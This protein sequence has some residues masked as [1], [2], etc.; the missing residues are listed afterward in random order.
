MRLV[1]AMAVMLA[2]ILGSWWYMLHDFR[3]HATAMQRLQNQVSVLVNQLVAT[4]QAMRQVSALRQ[5]V[6]SARRENDARV[7]E[8]LGMCGIERFDYL[9]RLLEE[10]RDRRGACTTHSPASAAG[11][12]Q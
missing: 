12:L 6:E 3:E 4:D 1:V 9:E 10:D 8:A 7:Q 11:A 2:A 5:E